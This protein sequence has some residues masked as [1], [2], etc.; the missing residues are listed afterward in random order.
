MESGKNELAA[1]LVR[2]VG[3]LRLAVV[4][5]S[6]LPAIRPRD[7][8]IIRRCTIQAARV[9]DVVLFARGER[10][11]A[12]RVIAAGAKALVTRGDALPAPDDPV[13]GSELLGR[14]ERV[15][16]R[17]RAFRPRVPRLGGRIAAGLFRRSARAGRV[18]TRIDGLKRRLGW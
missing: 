1:A 10:L 15:V 18:L 16:R 11:F 8:L 4:G 17:G 13:E 12:H 2:T 5:S 3:K 7:L 6:M 14:V 9:G